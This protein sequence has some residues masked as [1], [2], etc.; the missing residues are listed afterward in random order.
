MAD[1]AYG[2]LL[3]SPTGKH[4]RTA[5]L[6]CDIARHAWNTVRRLYPDTMPALNPFAGVTREKLVKDKP[7]ATYTEMCDLVDALL[8]HV[9]S[10]ALAVAALICWGW[11]QRPEN[12]LDGYITWADYRP[13]CRPSEVKVF[14]H[15]TGVEHWLP[16]VF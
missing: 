15:K 6:A 9:D 8:I 11:H 3:N 2:K 14:H 1:D 13:A 7:A 5:N 4:Y 16:L 10:M 12:V